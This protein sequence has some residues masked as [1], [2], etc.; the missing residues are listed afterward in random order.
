MVSGERSVRESADLCAPSR[1]EPRKKRRNL[2][3]SKMRGFL[4]ADFPNGLERIC[5]RVFG[6]HRRRLALVLKTEH[7][8]YECVGPLYHALGMFLFHDDFFHCTREFELR[9]VLARK[10]RLRCLCLKR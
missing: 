4:S 6:N 1:A 10:F 7:I 3:R 9:S 8:F 5:I 2:A